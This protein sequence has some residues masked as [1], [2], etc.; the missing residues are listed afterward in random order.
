MVTSMMCRIHQSG[1]LDK[2]SP[3]SFRQVVAAIDQYKKALRKHIP[4]AVPFYPL[5]MP[6]VTDAESPVALGMRAPGLTWM[7]VWRM[8][9]SPTV[10]I[11]WAA[12][13]PRVLF[14]T[15]LG[16]TLEHEN[17]RLRVKFPKTKMACVISV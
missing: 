3:E 17:D 6:D 11:P 1:R 13:S 9:G 4:E 15:D 14:P 8:N 10:E 7:A 16:I 5:G 2:L 12:M